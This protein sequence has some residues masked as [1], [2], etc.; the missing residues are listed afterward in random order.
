[1]R[2]K[3]QLGV[4]IGRGLFHGLPEGKPLPVQMPPE[5]IVDQA[6]ANSQET[7]VSHIAKV[8]GIMGAGWAFAGIGLE[9][10]LWASSGFLLVSA[11]AQC[12]LIQMTN[13]DA[14]T[15]SRD[16]FSARDTI[17]QLREAVAYNPYRHVAPHARQIPRFVS[18]PE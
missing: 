17:S 6:K 3:Q 15:R 10:V 12:G 2:L 5:M 14:G 18:V 8:A 11:L 1:M 7:T 16:R 9:G 13:Q 4:E